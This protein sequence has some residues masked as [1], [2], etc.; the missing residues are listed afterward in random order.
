MKKFI[1]FPVLITAFI[2]GCKEDSIIEPTI[3]GFLAKKNAEEIK[4]RVEI[5][6]IEKNDTITIL[7]DNNLPNDEVLVVK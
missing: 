7:F 1:L 3:T 2:S 6:S 4:G 5:Y